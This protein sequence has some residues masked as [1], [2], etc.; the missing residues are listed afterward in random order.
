MPLAVNYGISVTWC[1]N[2]LQRSHVCN[3][4]CVLQVGWTVSLRRRRKSW[5]CI[6]RA[7]H[8]LTTSYFMVWRGDALVTVR[9]KIFH[10]S[11]ETRT[12]FSWR[13]LTD[14][15]HIRTSILPIIRWGLHRSLWCVLGVRAAKLTGLTVKPDSHTIDQITC[16]G[17][18]VRI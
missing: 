1:S 13:S 18:T 16:T 11:F 15:C 6:E 17:S 8:W 4:V 10:P 7:I 5:K 2:S 12:L 3:G 9:P 14:T